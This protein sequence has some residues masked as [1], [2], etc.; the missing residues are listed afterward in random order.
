MTTIW[1]ARR[2]MAAASFDF[3]SPFTTF[4]PAPGVTANTSYIADH[5]GQLIGIADV[6]VSSSYSDYRVRSSDFIL[7]IRLGDLHHLVAQLAIV[8]YEQGLLRD[9]IVLHNL[10]LAIGAK[11]EN[12]AGGKSGPQASLSVSFQQII[13]AR[14]SLT[15][16]GCAFRHAAGMRAFTSPAV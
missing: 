15:L 7:A 14:A 10:Q 11:A 5:G 2:I 3:L 13:H 9:S 4:A 1:P 6:E 8:H 16:T 12:G